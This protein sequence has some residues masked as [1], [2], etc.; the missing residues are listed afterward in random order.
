MAC[1]LP[2]PPPACG[3]GASSPVT[4]EQSALAGICRD[5]VADATFRQCLCE[6]C[7]RQV[8]FLVD[9]ELTQMAAEDRGA[10][11]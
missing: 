1:R 6:G 3:A 5:E 2:L 11:G 10:A 7:R 8:D 4:W 9:E